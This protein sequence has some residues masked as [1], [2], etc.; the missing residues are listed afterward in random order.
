MTLLRQKSLVIAA[1]GL[2]G[3]LAIFSGLGTTTTPEPALPGFGSQAPS[4]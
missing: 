1:A 4:Q 3:G 2:L